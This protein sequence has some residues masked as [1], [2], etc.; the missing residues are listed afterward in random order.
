MDTFSEA[1]KIGPRRQTSLITRVD[2]AVQE[3]SCRDGKVNSIDDAQAKGRSLQ[4]KKLLRII[5]L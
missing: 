5:R 3:D 2:I 1:M 4:S